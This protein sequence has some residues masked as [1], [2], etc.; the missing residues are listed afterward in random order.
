MPESA[1]R[2]LLSSQNK[3]VQESAHLFDDKFLL[4]WEYIHF[5]YIPESA[6]T[7]N[8]IFTDE[9]QDLFTIADVSVV[10]AHVPSEFIG[11]KLPLLLSREG[12]TRLI[13]DPRRYC[14]IK[15]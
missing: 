12:G 4:C 13:Q 11:Q 1:F 15:G 6:T 7:H 3:A 14:F 5:R 10:L 2:R 9:W 8:F